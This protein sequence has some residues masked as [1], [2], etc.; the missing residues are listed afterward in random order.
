[1][2]EDTWHFATF[3]F[4]SFF[5]PS[6]TMD[7][8]AVQLLCLEQREFIELVN[9]TH[10]PDRSLCVFYISS[11][12]E[13]SCANLPGSG[14]QQD[15]V[16]CLEWVLQQQLSIHHRPRRAYQHLFTYPSA[17][18]ANTQLDGATAWFHHRNLCLPWRKSQWALLS[19][20]PIQSLSPI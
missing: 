9:L 17:Q 15:F 4:H 1:M 14:P 10:Y 12:S 7:L 2:T 8:P 18:S 3:S 13:R 11:L 19:W 5:S 6:I 20:D 16:A